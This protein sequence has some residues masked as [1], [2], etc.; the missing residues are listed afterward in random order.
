MH[1]ELDPGAVVRL[2]EAA[3]PL[4]TPQA[5]EGVLHG[6]EAPRREAARASAAPE[7]GDSQLVAGYH[8][9]A[10]AMRL[11]RVAHPPSGGKCRGHGPETDP[12]A[13]AGRSALPAAGTGR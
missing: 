2:Q 8:A 7:Q 9:L 4:K 3:N 11:E 10:A 1:R 6:A 12:A 5:V 13:G